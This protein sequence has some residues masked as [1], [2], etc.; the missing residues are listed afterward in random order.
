MRF[1]DEMAQF[2]I[3]HL[4]ILQFYTLIVGGLQKKAV[5][6]PQNNKYETY[7]QILPC[8]YYYADVMSCNNIGA[9]GY[10]EF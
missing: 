3:S 1:V 5:S 6:L 8:I 2:Y 4:I 7:N 10:N 9:Y